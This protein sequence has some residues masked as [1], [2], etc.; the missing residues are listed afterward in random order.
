M[1]NK[2]YSYW[3]ERNDCVKYEYERYVREHIA[4]HYLHRFRHLR[5][6]V[7]LNRHFI[8]R[9]K[10]SPMIYW[11]DPR[12][13]IYLANGET[14]NLIS[15][16]SVESTLPPSAIEIKS[17]ISPTEKVNKESF[18]YIRKKIS[19]SEKS[20][21]LFITNTTRARPILDPSVRYR[22]YHPAEVL[23]SQGIYTSVITLAQFIKEPLPLDFDL[24]I[25]HRPGTAAIDNIRKLKFYNKAIVADY[26]DLIFGDEKFA[27]K[28]SLFLNTNHDAKE[29]INIFN[30]NLEALKEF[31][32]FT[33]STDSLAE[34]IKTQCKNAKVF[35]IHNFLPPSILKKTAGYIK[36][37][38]DMNQVVYCC[39]T[40]SHNMDFKMIEEAIIRCLKRD[41][42]LRFFII[43]PLSINEEINRLANVYFHSVVDYWD[44][45]E[46]MSGSAFAIAPLEDSIFNNCKSNV[47]FLESA[48]TG[49]T[50]LA[51]PI[52]D[53]T[54]VENSKIAL[55]RNEN[56][57]ENYIMNRYENYNENS[58]LSNRMYLEQFCSAKTFNMEFATLLKHLKEEV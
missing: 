49:V 52:P 50:L 36:K 28:S 39:G 1:N 47:K 15:A 11:D 55:C 41:V 19:I 45:F 42:S 2:L 16:K 27:L 48:A 51:S 40:Q 3:V 57:F 53:M 22:C 54:R 9:K 17:K 6:L 56:D 23:Y 34:I 13:P 21:I 37:E 8:S 38:K 33:C 20:R 35:V 24:Y 30:R 32:T 10:N 4:E 12:H 58:K 5:L 46:I 25:F 7:K 29:V 18:N 14:N 44:L 43:G 26:D 31:D